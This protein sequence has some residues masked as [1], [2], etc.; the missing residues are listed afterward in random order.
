MSAKPT[1]KTPKKTVVKVP[2]KKS[3]RIEHLLQL[4]KELDHM[5]KAK[6]R[7]K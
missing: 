4:L 7:E 2:K 3:L 5:R 1:S 6:R